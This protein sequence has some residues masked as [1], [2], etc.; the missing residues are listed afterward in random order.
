[1]K[2]KTVPKYKKHLRTEKYSLY[3][4]KKASGRALEKKKDA[5]TGSTEREGLEENMRSRS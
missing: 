5:W 3:E 1:M 2:S 4:E